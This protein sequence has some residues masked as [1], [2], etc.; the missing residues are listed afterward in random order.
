MW[1]SGFGYMGREEGHVR[2][3][4]RRNCNQNILYLKSLFN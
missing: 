1:R 4:G 2:S 3:W